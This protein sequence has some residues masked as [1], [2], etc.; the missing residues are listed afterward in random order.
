MFIKGMKPFY[1]ILGLNPGVTGYFDK[2]DTSTSIVSSSTLSLH[3]IDDNLNTRIM[4]VDK[5]ND[6]D[7]AGDDGDVDSDVIIGYSKK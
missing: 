4:Y 6:W 3:F 7:F 2:G 5:I 1:A